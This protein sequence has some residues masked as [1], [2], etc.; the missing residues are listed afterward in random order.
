MMAAMSSNST[1]AD[2]QGQTLD[3]A[4]NELQLEPNTSIVSLWQ[5]FLTI[6]R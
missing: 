1:S 6:R 4:H 2:M 5:D 3:N